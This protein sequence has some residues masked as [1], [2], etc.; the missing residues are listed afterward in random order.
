MASGN[1]IG[2]GKTSSYLTDGISISFGISLSLAKMMVRVRSSSIPG[3][4][5][6]VGVARVGRVANSSGNSSSI[7]DSRY[8][9][10]SSIRDGWGSSIRDSRC[11]SVRNS[12]GSSIR[13]S[14]SSSYSDAIV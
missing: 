8:C 11:S 14:R 4:T 1:S 2:I 9:G 5:S 3:V 10:G 13:E 6:C 7:R 12:R